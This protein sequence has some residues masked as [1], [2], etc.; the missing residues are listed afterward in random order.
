[1]DLRKLR[2]GEE[3]T[4]PRLP[5]VQATKNLQELPRTRKYIDAIA[6]DAVVTSVGKIIYNPAP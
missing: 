2:C 1:M 6:H 4:L 3:A 5:S